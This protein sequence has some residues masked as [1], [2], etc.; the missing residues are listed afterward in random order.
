MS[1]NQ[2]Q[3]AVRSSEKFVKFFGELSPIYRDYI[4]YGKRV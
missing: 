4:A 1:K 2:I 3:L